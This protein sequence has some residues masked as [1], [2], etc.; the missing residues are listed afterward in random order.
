MP[1]D[2][3]EVELDKRPVKSFT[4]GGDKGFTQVGLEDDGSTPILDVKY[5]PLVQLWGEID[6]LSGFLG[7]TEG[8]FTGYQK[9]L[10][11]IM[12]MLYF[13]K[14]DTDKINKQISRMEKFCMKYETNLGKEF[15]LLSGYVNL[16]RVWARRVERRLWEVIGNNKNSDLR[17]LAKFFNR[18]SSYLFI[19]TACANEIT[20]LE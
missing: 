17:V 2:Q 20:D 6:E 11:E 16:S 7:M 13:N 9:L 1:Q 19:H 4:R 8:R 10:S 3:T 15:M 14:I 12:S 5:S 18:F